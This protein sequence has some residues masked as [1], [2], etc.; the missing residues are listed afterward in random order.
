[1]QC[2]KGFAMKKF[3]ESW[4]WFRVFFSYLIAFSVLACCIVLPF[5]CAGFLSGYIG[6]ALVLSM[7]MIDMDEETKN[8]L[9]KW[10]VRKNDSTDDTE[11]TEER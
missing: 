7:L 2:Q 9:K 6:W 4:F 11:S 8:A 1:M 10:A 3:K 5:G